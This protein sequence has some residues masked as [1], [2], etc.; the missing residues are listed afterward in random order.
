MTASA[1]TLPVYKSSAGKKQV[2]GTNK[3]FVDASADVGD[4]G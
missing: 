4:D 3:R 1:C 2:T